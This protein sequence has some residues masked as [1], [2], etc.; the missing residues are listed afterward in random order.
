MRDVPFATF[1]EVL[2]LRQRTLAGFLGVVFA[3]VGALHGVIDL[4][5]LGPL[6]LR[7]IRLS[8]LW[9]KHLLALVVVHL[10]SHLACLH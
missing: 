4:A 7:V 2:D 10:G 8:L 9:R 1:D 5:R 3:R 6:L